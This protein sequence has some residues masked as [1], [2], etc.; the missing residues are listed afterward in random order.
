MY[1]A[2]L[3]ALGIAGLI[4]LYRRRSYDDL[5]GLVIERFIQPHPDEME[6]DNEPH[7]WATPRPLTRYNKAHWLLVQM[8]E[9]FDTVTND[10]GQRVMRDRTIPECWDQWTPAHAKKRA[11]QAKRDG[12]DNVLPLRR[13]VQ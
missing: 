3:G 9:D 11:Q 12:S 8:H 7:H 13:A 10:K 5:P 2:I 1:E 6:V 4:W